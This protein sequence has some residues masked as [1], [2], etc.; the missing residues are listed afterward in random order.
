MLGGL[1][2][3]IVRSVGS[4]VELARSVGTII[5][6]ARS[7][8]SIAELDTTSRALSLRLPASAFI[9]TSQLPRHLARIKARWI[10]RS[11]KLVDRIGSSLS[12]L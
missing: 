8:E 10:D 11:H 2:V 4:I 3:F 12:E 6:V 1:L 7:A 9:L 5:E